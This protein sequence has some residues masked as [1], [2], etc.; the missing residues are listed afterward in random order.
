[1]AKGL[2]D[3]CDA[4]TIRAWF[5]W[6]APGLDF[7]LEDDYP[8]RRHYVYVLV[9]EG[10]PFYVGLGTGR[11]W[12]QHW[13]KP[14]IYNVAKD[15]KISDLN[16]RGVPMN[17]C[18]VIVKEH[19]TLNQAALIEQALIAEIG[20][21]PFG[22]LVNMSDGGDGGTFGYKWTPDQLARNAMRNPEAVAKVIAKNK[23]SKRSA[24]A[25]GNMR[26]AQQENILAGQHRLG[27]RET[28]EQTEARIAAAK[29][30]LA[31][32]PLGWIT[33][34]ILERRHPTDEP[35]PYGWRGGRLPESTPVKVG[36]IIGPRSEQARANIKAGHATTWSD[37][38]KR[39]AMMKNRRPFSWWTDGTQSKR[40]PDDQTPPTGWRPGRAI[41][42]DALVASR[43][44]KRKSDDDGGQPLI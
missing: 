31:E 10:A 29:A 18:V 30:S 17:N 28:P 35:V 34:S 44:Q 27:F 37:P 40:V 15:Q 14:S 33:N 24:D 1:M 13:D 20:R 6:T 32:R 38:A 39:E 5:E 43:N 2:R 25:V 3:H 41:N 22:P 26:V 42:V 16:R 4:R 8:S 23:G 19:L 9:D 11:R 36:D 12:K 7:P 21:D